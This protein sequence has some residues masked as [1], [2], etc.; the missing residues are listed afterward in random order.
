MSSSVVHEGVTCDGCGRTNFSGVRHK[1]LLCY[2]FDLCQPCTMTGITTRT[3][4]AS[5][6]MQAIVSPVDYESMLLDECG[7]NPPSSSLGGLGDSL[8]FYVCPY[9]GLDA[10]TD[11]TLYEHVLDDHTNDPTQVECPVCMTMGASHYTRDLPSHLSQSHFS[12][13]SSSRSTAGVDR[14]M[15][16][17]ILRRVSG[18]RISNSLDPLTE[19]LSQ[20]STGRKP[21]QQ[22][23]APM[24][25]RRSSPVVEKKPLLFKSTEPVL[26]EEAQKERVAKNEMR[27]AFV[28]ELLLSTLLP[29]S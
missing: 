25:P 19:L 4:N 3:H 17:Q 24:S 16:R 8:S 11:Q 14:L 23:P 6:P 22:Q 20:F 26:S 21:K 15:R 18:K 12:S 27:G 1:C 13:G 7:G 28:Q 9:C 29:S 5:H 10:L 2:D